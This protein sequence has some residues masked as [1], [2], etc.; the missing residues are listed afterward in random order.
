MFNC[1][2]SR[3]VATTLSIATLSIMTL[4]IRTFIII[5]KENVTLSITAP[6][7]ML[8]VIYAEYHI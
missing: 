6:S 3:N 8:T 2:G 1:T 4:I 7:I 5:K